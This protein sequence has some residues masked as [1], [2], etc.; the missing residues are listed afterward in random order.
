MGWNYRVVHRKFDSTS[1]VEDLYF[2]AEIYYNDDGSISS[3]ITYSEDEDGMRKCFG[4][5]KLMYPSGQDSIEDLKGCLE[6]MT[7]ALER[8]ILEYE[9]LLKL[10]D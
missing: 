6:Y 8:P 7:Q 2:I 3:Y 10:S 5:V 9:D 1:Y 4:D